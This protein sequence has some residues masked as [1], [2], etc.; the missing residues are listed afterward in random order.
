MFFTDASL[1]L[2]ALKARHEEMATHARK[3]QQLTTVANTLVIEWIPSHCCIPENEKADSLGKHSAQQQLEENGK[4]IAYRE[5]TTLVKHSIKGKGS[6]NQ[7][8][9]TRDDNLMT[10]LSTPINRWGLGVFIFRTRHCKLCVHLYNK[11]KI[12]LT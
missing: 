3:L 12:G 5:M 9:Q 2:Q 4:M 8:L 10:M 1:V 11:M 6:A 7:D